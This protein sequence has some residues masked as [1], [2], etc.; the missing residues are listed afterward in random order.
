[1]SR[2]DERRE[3]LSTADHILFALTV[4]FVIACVFGCCGLWG[5]WVWGP[6]WLPAGFRRPPVSL[7]RGFVTFLSPAVTPDG[8]LGGH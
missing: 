2:P 4:A 5:L 1:M 6:P 3:E 7:G 8:P